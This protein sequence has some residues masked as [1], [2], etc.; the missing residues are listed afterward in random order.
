ML[1]GSLVG[2]IAISLLRTCVECW[3]LRG[4]VNFKA[5]EG[6]LKGT[7]EIEGDESEV[8]DDPKGFDVLTQIA[9]VPVSKSIFRFIE[10][11]P[12]TGP[13]TGTPAIRPQFAP[14]AY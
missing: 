6:G 7:P 13:G 14:P 4:C 10:S 8:E 9:W 3:S 5:F 11:R 12:R 2:Y 1:M